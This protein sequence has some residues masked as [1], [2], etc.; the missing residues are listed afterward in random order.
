LSQR[1][2][3]P[4]SART[5]LECHTRAARAAWFRRLEERV[6]TNRSGKPVGRSRT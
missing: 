5:R 1:M 3:V 2:C 6:Y 4:C